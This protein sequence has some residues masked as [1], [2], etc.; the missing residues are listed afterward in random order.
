MLYTAGWLVV[1]CFTSQP[2]QYR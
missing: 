1:Q 2:T